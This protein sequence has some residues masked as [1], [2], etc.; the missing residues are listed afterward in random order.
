MEGWAQPIDY[1]AHDGKEKYCKFTS[2]DAFIEDYW[3]FLKR[4]VYDGWNC[5][6]H[7]PREFIRFLLAC[8]YT[9]SNTYLDE[10]MR[11]LPNAMLALSD[12]RKP[13]M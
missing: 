6:T 3:R 10:V 1:E 11:L 7:P 8:G 12:G 9:E 4:P 2:D 13:K 5:H